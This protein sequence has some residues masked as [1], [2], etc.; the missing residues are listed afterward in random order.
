VTASRAVPTSAVPRVGFAVPF[1]QRRFALGRAL[2]VTP[3]PTRPPPPAPRI[4]GRC[5][6]GHP[7]PWAPFVG[8]RPLDWLLGLTDVR[9][10]SHVCVTCGAGLVFAGLSI[11]TIVLALRRYGTDDLHDV[12]CTF[13]FASCRTYTD[14]PNVQFCYRWGLPRSRTSVQSPPPSAPP[15]CLPPPARGMRRLPPPSLPPL[16]RARHH[17]RSQRASGWVPPRAHP[18]PC[19]SAAGCG[20]SGWRPLTSVAVAA[21]LRVGVCV[22]ACTRAHACVRVLAVRRQCP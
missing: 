20:L 11:L 15:S 6:P 5:T 4:C 9:V 12:P 8:P 16:A 17:C 1:G 22:Y 13:S 7:P 10:C 2:L 14:A 3:P 18:L 21:L 19:A